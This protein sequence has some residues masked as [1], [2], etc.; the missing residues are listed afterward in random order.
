MHDPTLYLGSN[1]LVLDKETTN[2]QYGNAVEE[3]NSLVLSSW[4]YQGKTTSIYNNEFHQDELLSDIESADFLVGHNIKFDLKWLKRCGLDLTNVVIYDTM[5]GEYVLKGNT[6][7][8]SDLGLGK[9]S[10]RYGFGSK[11]PF[12]DICMKGKVCP[13]EMPR[14]FL[15]RRCEKDILQTEQIF[16]KQREN[17]RKYGLLPVFYTRCLLTPCLADMEMEGMALDAEAV[18]EEY[19]STSVAY[20]EAQRQFEE[21]SGGINPRSPKQMCAFVYGELG[22]KPIKVRGEE[23][24]S[25]SAAILA[26]LKATNKKQRYF[27]ELQKRISK[28]NARLTKSLNKFKECVEN[29]D[30]LYAEFNQTITKTHR[31]SSSGTKYKTQFQ[32]LPRE[33]K[34]LLQAKEDGWYMVEVD[35]AQLEFRVAAFLGQDPQAVDDIMNDF[36]VHTFTAQTLTEAG[37]ETSRQEAKAHSFKPLFGG[38]SGTK[39]EQAYYEAFKDKYKGIAQ[40]QKSW[41]Y[42]VLRSKCLRIASGLVAYWKDTKMSKSGY[43]T[44]TTQIYNLPVQSLATA[45]I[46]PIAIVQLWRRMKKAG[47]QSRLVNTVHDSVIAEVHPDEVEVYKELALPAFSSDVYTYLET[48]YG[49]R[50]NVPLGVGIKIGYNWGKADEELAKAIYEKDKDLYN[51]E[52]DDGE[53]KYVPECPYAGLI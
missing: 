7:L 20:Q 27:L 31:L 4:T 25:A 12:V 46:I 22:F 34:P 1:Y 53:L 33:Y 21:L 5:I 36:D 28:L 30:I 8:L 51:V 29:E 43:I 18:M 6:A 35:G 32:N 19:R 16:L 45:D 37:Q 38:M 52:L 48:V 10:E 3:E 14:S 23:K 17:L 9:T 47:L 41:T 49:I 50:F 44:N 39:A 11:D 40:A 15:I 42:D 24:L 26:Q 2:I 13:S